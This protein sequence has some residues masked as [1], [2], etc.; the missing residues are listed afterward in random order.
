MYERHWCCCCCFCSF[1]QTEL[2]THSLLYVNDGFGGLILGIVLRL[3][4][5]I[6]QGLEL[7][8]GLLNL[9][10]NVLVNEQSAI[11][12]AFIHHLLLVRLSWQRNVLLLFNRLL[13]LFIG[14]RSL[15]NGDIWLLF[16]RHH[17]FLNLAIF[18]L[19]GM[20]TACRLVVYL[21]L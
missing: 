2:H 13:L 3:Q 20:V 8:N 7:L 6:N 5:I 16:E 17:A 11:E 1:A 10:E 15:G 19:F 12:A 21:L 9:L 14:C 18:I 4:F